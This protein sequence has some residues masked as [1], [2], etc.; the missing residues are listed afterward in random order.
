MI[1]ERKVFR[2]ELVEGRWMDWEWWKLERERQK[3]YLVWLYT[4]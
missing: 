4:T 1:C 3:E 2:G